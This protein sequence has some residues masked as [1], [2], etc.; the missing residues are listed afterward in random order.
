M[1]PSER[2]ASSSRS[3]RC[4]K[5]TEAGILDNLNGV[6]DP[7]AVAAVSRRLRRRKHAPRR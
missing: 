4:F 5:E 6:E 2:M 3:R 7:A 1:T